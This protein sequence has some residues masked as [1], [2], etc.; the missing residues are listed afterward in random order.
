MNLEHEIK[1]KAIDTVLKLVELHQLN[2]EHGKEIPIKE[3]VEQFLEAV[4]LIVENIKENT[5]R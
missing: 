3:S 1:F 5:A 4:N 2:F